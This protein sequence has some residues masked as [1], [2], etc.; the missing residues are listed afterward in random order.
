MVIRSNDSQPASRR[1]HQFLELGSV[2]LD[3][4]ACDAEL[5][6]CEM[7]LSR[8]GMWQL[9]N[10]S[11]SPIPSAPQALMCGQVPPAAIPTPSSSCSIGDVA[12]PADSRAGDRGPH[13]CKDEAEGKA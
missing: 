11:R 13:P 4:S 7:Q 5:D 10:A 6:E 8:D 2:W 1:E 3:L 12:L 9:S